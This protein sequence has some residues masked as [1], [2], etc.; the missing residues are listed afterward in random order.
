MASSLG[1]VD[2]GDSDSDS[3]DTDMESS[4]SGSVEE[5]LSSNP[6]YNGKSVNS[7]RLN[8][9]GE[10]QIIDQEVKGSNDIPCQDYD[11]KDDSLF[12]EKNIATPEA[13][14]RSCGPLPNQNVVNIAKKMKLD[15]EEEDLSLPSSIASMYQRG[16]G[17]TDDPGQH[18]N[19]VRSFPHVEGN[20]ATHVYIEVEWNSHFFE[21]VSRVLEELRP[22]EF[23]AL[24]EFHISLSRTVAIRHHWIEPLV[25]SLRDQF[26]P[27]HASLCDLAT[28]KL[29]TNDEKTRTFLC[30]EISEEDADLLKSYVAAVDRSFAEFKLQK[31]YE[32]PSFHMSLGWCLGDVTCGVSEGVMNRV[33]EMF[34]TFMAQH[35][36]LSV[37]YTRHVTVRSGNKCVEI[38]LLE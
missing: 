38:P 24:P 18:H 26:R 20:W 30:L 1:L 2:Y 31:Y 35:S 32:N 12:K 19:R 7:R 27:L 5:K 8:N 14:P 6:Q 15:S 29:F 34:G 4:L 11:M 10:K 25:D 37:V 33:K 36:E 9:S 23:H 21:F 16:P 13:V 17:W 28:V 3:S 22:L